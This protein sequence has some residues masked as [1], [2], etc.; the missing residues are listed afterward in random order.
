M[1]RLCA[2]LGLALL[3]GC[4]QNAQ[5]K[6]SNC[7]KKDNSC[8][9]KCSSSASADANVQEKAVAQEA[10]PAAESVITPSN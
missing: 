5:E 9:K 6:N 7:P 3:I 1:K 10:A 8:P 2:L 4:G